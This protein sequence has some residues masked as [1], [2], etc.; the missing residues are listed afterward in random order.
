M[1]A[2][3][4]P[5]SVTTPWVVVTL[6][7]DFLRLSCGITGDPDRALCS[8]C[9]DPCLAVQF[10]GD[11]FAA[12]VAWVASVAV[13]VVESTI[14]AV[15]ALAFAARRAS[16]P[17]GPAVQNAAA[18]RPH[19]AGSGISRIESNV[20]V[21]PRWDNSP[22]NIAAG[23]PATVVERGGHGE[24]LCA[25]GVVLLRILERCHARSGATIPGRLGPHVV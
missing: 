3:I 23:R 4:E 11:A 18:L 8:C 13:A 20:V 12:A 22:P 2:H 6:M 16:C 17:G 19:A 9:P 1:S 5:S 7:S 21:L 24:D 14:A 10:G 15:Q 25:A